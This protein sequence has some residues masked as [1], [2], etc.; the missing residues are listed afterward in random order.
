MQ[1]FLRLS[2]TESVFRG[3]GG[4]TVFTQE[5]GGVPVLRKDRPFFLVS[6]TSWTEDEDFRLLLQA[7]ESELCG[8]CV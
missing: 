2:E 8:D 3:E 6:S 5:E 4:G 7:L 1:L